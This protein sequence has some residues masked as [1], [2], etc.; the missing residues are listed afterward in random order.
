MYQPPPLKVRISQWMIKHVYK[1]VLQFKSSFSSVKKKDI[2]MCVCM[3]GCVCVC[4]CVYM[5]YVSGAPVRQ[6]FQG[7]TE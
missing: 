6:I 5:L 2:C 7:N 4:V 1:N 3:R